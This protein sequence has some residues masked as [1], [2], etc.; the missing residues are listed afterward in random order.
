VSGSLSG[1]IRGLPGVR[2]QPQEAV[3]QS[4]WCNQGFTRCQ[5]PAPGGCLAVERRNQGFASS[6]EP[7]PRGSLGSL[8]AQSGIDHALGASSGGCP[9]SLRMA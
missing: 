1:G 6:Q 3:R 5:G 4:E 7:T 2:G 8:K 9:D